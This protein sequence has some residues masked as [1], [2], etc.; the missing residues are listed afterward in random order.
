M[1]CTSSIC[2][3]V[4]STWKVVEESILRLRLALGQCLTP[5]TTVDLPEFDVGNAWCKIFDVSW[6]VILAVEKWFWTVACTFIHAW[7]GPSVGP[8]CSCSLSLLVMLVTEMIVF[9]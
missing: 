9:L 1:V 3:S 7:Y 6:A 2:V 4:A 5:K 8:S